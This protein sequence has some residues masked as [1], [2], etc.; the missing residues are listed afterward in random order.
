MVPEAENLGAPVKLQL[1][2]IAAACALLSGCGGNDTEAAVLASVKTAA[3][4]NP[5]LQFSHVS[6]CADTLDGNR[7]AIVSA[8]G[9]VQAGSDS[10]AGGYFVEVMADGTVG[11]AVKASP[12]DGTATYDALRIDKAYCEGKLV[13]GP[14]A[15][16]DQLEE[17]QPGTYED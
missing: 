2:C 16:F 15:A 6:W 5:E 9:P 14:Q 8:V 4:D 3:G 11:P 10:G 7:A 12:P 13:A 17:M 1:V